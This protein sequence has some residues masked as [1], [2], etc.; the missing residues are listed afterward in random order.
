MSRR[1]RDPRF[2]RPVA[3]QLD[4]VRLCVHQFPLRLCHAPSIFRGIVRVLRILRTWPAC[5]C[6]PLKPLGNRFVMSTVYGRRSVWSP[7]VKQVLRTDLKGKTLRV[8]TYI[9][10]QTNGKHN[11]RIKSRTKTLLTASIVWASLCQT[12]L[13][14]W[15]SFRAGGSSRV[16]GALPVQWNPVE[17]I[18]WQRELPG[19]G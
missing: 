17:G 2:L 6:V 4:C 10:K 5:C 13:S 14:D 7:F 9:Y 15:P 11:V 18:A 19:Y 16:N 1:L 8:S 3:K 12:V